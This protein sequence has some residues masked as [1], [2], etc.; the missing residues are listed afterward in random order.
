MPRIAHRSIRFLP[1][2]TLGVPCQASL[3]HDSAKTRRLVTLP[4]PLVVAPHVDVAEQALILLRLE[5]VDGRYLL[6]ASA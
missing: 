5:R 2:V 3:A 1:H 6:G 4:P